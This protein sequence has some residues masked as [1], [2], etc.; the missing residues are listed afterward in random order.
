MGKYYHNRRLARSGNREAS[1]WDESDHTLNRQEMSQF[2]RDCI[3]RIEAE[4]A[5]KKS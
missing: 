5:Q 1:A 4:K 2:D 3:A